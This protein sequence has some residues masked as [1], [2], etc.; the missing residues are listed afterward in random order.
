[1]L[2]LATIKL[3][4]QLVFNGVVTGLV[5]GMLAMGIVLIYRS[6]RVINFAVGN[7]GLVG[8]T[9]LA[10]LTVNWGV[11]FSIA[12]ILSLAAGTLFGLVMELIVVRRLFYA[13]RVIMLVATIG[14][15]G[16]ALTVVFA[17][18]EI[19]DT[20]A[21]YPVAINHTWTDVAG[22]DVRGTQLAVL[23]VVP[24]VAI[25]LGWFLNRTLIGR[26]VKASAENPDLARIQGINPKLVSTAVWA[27]A[28]F[29]ATLTMILIAGESGAASDLPTLGPNTLVRALVAAVI[30]GLVS[31]PRAM[32]AGVAIGVVEA[33]IQF[34]YL[35]KPGLTDLLLFLAVL[36]AV[37]LQSRTSREETQT[38]KF[39]PKIR[40]IPEQLRDVWWVKRLNLMVMV[41]LVALAALVPLVITAA[42]K[43]LLYQ[44]IG[45]FAICALSLIVLT[46]WGGQLSLG[47]MAFAGIGAL[48]AAGLERGQHYNL[49]LVDIHPG[50]VPFALA[51]LIAALL[52]S[53]L[54]AII[55]LGALRVRGLLLAVSTFVFAV[56]AQ[57]Y[58]YRQPALSGGSAS[59]VNFPRGKVFG[60]DLTPQRNYYWAV[61]LVLV[62]VMILVSHLRRT[63]IGRTTIAV[64]DNENSAAAYTVGRSSTKL[65][66]FALAG[67]LAGLGGA[68]L[69]GAIQSIPFTERYFLVGDSL[70][71][72]S[73]VVI[74]GISS[75]M[76]AVLGSLWVVGLPTFFPDND[77]VPLLT[78]SLGLLVLLLYFPGGFV[79][80]GY[81]ARDAFLGWVAARRGEVDTSRRADAPAALTRQV[82]QPAPAG[83]PALEVVDVRVRFG[84]N[85]AVDGVSLTVGTD[86]IV[87][88]IG[89]NG[90]GKS[91]LMNAIGGYVRSRGTVVLHGDDVSRYGAARRARDGLGRTF[92]AAQ[93]FAELTVRETVEV[94]LEARG[95][96]G[97][98]SAA[99]F[100]PHASVR[101]RRRRAEADDLIGF[102]G[103]GRYASSRISDLSTGTRRIVELAGL[104]ALDARVL[105][106]D[107]PTAG[108]AQRETEAFG[109]L[110]KEIRRELGAA[111]LVIEHDMP[112]IMSIS[113]R[114]YC[115]EV[116]KVIAEGVPYTVRHDPKVVASYLGVDERAIA[117]SGAASTGLATE[118]AADELWVQ[119]T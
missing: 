28:G 64:R 114:V 110:I 109:P 67:F 30:A 45:C 88:L 84:G 1:M 77:L 117:R 61:L 25:A 23:I 105:C 47:Q 57:V 37:A 13:P 94:A 20:S 79:Q 115:L 97:F 62:V 26:T 14:I 52:T 68:M 71:L 48:L 11:P 106:L 32:L 40:E 107:E 69:A 2:V 42:S 93:L 44:T 66:A 65:R 46:G 76:G 113:D 59:L 9:L 35:D 63:G 104:L 99:L 89:T 96:T 12:A 111:M 31:F 18:P 38:F 60:I 43:L 3:T 87:G 17:L 5:Y 24:L 95:R 80:V 90:A 36:V 15:A 108:V 53:G 70:L 41:F 39:T 92:Q 119:P 103:L 86:E 7:M 58:F 101:E 16:V 49:G 19:A 112:L 116:G 10:L 50:H 34:N 73:M 33:S 27:I 82:R 75:P 6:T 22:V 81:A 51:I 102:L 54:A 100:L 98:L 74:G 55:G 72:V 91:T 56:T 8:A 83:V 118:P 78:S 21:R 4:S 85:V 29:L